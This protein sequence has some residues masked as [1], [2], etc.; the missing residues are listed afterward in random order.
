MGRRLY[1]ETGQKVTRKR[2]GSMVI[3]MDF[4][5]MYDIARPVLMKV[6]SL[7]T[8]YLIFWLLSK[9]MGKSNMLNNARYVYEEFAGDLKQGSGKSVTRRMYTKC[10]TELVEL[11]IITRVGRGQY[12]FNP[13]YFW[14]D[15][16]GDRVKYI[17]AEV[18]ENR[19]KKEQVIKPPVKRKDKPL[20]QEEPD[21]PEGSLAFRIKYDGCLT[22]AEYNE[23]NNTA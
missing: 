6:R 14:K 17:T 10:F 3:E 8:F 15:K 16:S 5:Q 20:E 11:G 22:Y 1:Y 4:T 2:K 12:Y 21:S 23:K 7:T 13:H 9:Q 19:F 18:Q